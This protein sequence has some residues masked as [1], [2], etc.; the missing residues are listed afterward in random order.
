M[1]E[2]IAEAAVCNEVVG[3]IVGASHQVAAHHGEESAEGQQLDSSSLPNQ[4][5]QG[6]DRVQNSILNIPSTT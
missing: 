4:V 5:G 2:E 1:S 6:T 3:E